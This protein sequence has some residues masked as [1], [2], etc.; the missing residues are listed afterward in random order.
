VDFLKPTPIAPLLLEADVIEIAGRNAVIGSTLK[1]HEEVAA[2]L[3]GTFVAVSPNHPAAKRWTEKG[4]HPM[5][6][7]RRSAGRGGAP[8]EGTIGHQEEGLSRHKH[9]EPYDDRDRKQEYPDDAQDAEED[10]HLSDAFSVLRSQGR[11]RRQEHFAFQVFLP[12]IYPFLVVG[13]RFRKM[14]LVR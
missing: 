2:T 1:D 4:E 11:G 8:A 5:L 3:R 7:I 13:E 14:R 9:N 10:Q 12:P 6:L